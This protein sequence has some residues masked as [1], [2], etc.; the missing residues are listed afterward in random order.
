[1][2]KRIVHWTDPDYEEI[3]WQD[4]GSGQSITCR[5][6]PLVKPEAHSKPSR[7]VE[8]DDAKAINEPA[9]E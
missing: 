5:Q 7:T 8:D 4:W 3:F 6:A 9:G 2:K 1:M